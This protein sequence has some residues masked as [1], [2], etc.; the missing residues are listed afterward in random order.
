MGGHKQYR[1]MLATA[2]KEAVKQVAGEIAA[3]EQEAALEKEV[4]RQS[5][6]P[7]LNEAEWKSHIDKCLIPVVQ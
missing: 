3:R 7:P 6:N 5:D 4:Q 1:E 2:K